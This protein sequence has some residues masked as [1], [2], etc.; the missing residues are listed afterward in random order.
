VWIGVVKQE[1]SVPR[2]E[3]SVESLE[4]QLR[5]RNDEIERL[6]VHVDNM[7]AIN[8]EAEAEMAAVETEFEVA[9]ENGAE[10]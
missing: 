7:L 6:R 9:E 4:G 5:E 8:R 10:A 1:H 2:L 3:H